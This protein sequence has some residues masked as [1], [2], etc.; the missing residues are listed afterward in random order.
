MPDPAVPTVTPVPAETASSAV[1]ETAEPVPE[2]IAEPQ[3]A[4]AVEEGAVEP[5]TAVEAPSTTAEPAAVPQQ[6]AA[7]EPSPVTAAE[8]ELAVEAQAAPAQ[9]PA[10]A[11]PVMVTEPEAGPA[12]PETTAAI[13]AEAAT[14]E[15]STVETSA[16]EAT[17]AES[18]T[19]ESDTLAAGTAETA[20]VE[21][22]PVEAGTTEVAAVASS[23]EPASAAATAPPAGET[24]GTE[25][26]AATDRAI[27]EPASPSTV[28]L[29]P[30][31]LTE[32][33]R[34][35]LELKSAKESG[36]TVHGR[37]IGWNQGGFHVVIGLVTAF[38]PRSEME[39]KNP[40]S[41]S[42][43][44]DKEFE[45]KVIKHQ[46]KGRRIVLSR[47][48]VLETE[49]EGR[50]ALL[51]AQAAEGGPLCGRISSITDFGAFV[52]LGGVEG[53]VHLT[54]LSHR[55]VPHPRELVQLGQEVRV[56]VLKIEQGGDRISLTMKPFEE[57]PWE[58]F[59]AAHP[60]GSA[61]EGKIARKTD[62][63][64]FVELE[65]GFDGMIHLS[66]LPPGKGLDHGAY[67][68]GAPVTGWILK[69]EPERERI[70]LTL[71]EIPTEDPWRGVSERYSEGT[72][73]EGEVE[74]LTQFGAFVVLEP[75]LTGLLPNSA[76]KALRGPGSTN[77]GL[78][79]GQRVTVQVDSVDTGRK[80]ISL[81]LEG[82]QLTG[83][84]SD[85]KEYQRRQKQERRGMT[86][87]EA[88]FAKLQRK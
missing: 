60:R 81:A 9:E 41:P 80:R 47:K 25:P 48:Q 12:V 52:D 36:A 62:F 40:R 2:T 18:E 16:I 14:V 11:T 78:Q 10:A 54:E 71:R 68:V 6:D 87:M 43:Y 7:A 88:A 15:G 73:V 56:K 46:K 50:L 77:R 24:P 35:V 57:N 84:R 33:D 51:Q 20:P 31:Q 76:L 3:A 8:P 70:S 21:A 34:Q 37:V 85:L 32:H 61:F 44:L 82:Q 79:P 17:S 67:E 53:L 75:G 4:S 49:R 22:T 26:P 27:E 83:N 55:R 19:V 30:E 45:F 58:R 64:L 86:A 63:G 66:Q 42:F 23:T 72:V 59:G 28:H 39:I 38:C 65:P 29:T 74:E 1:T 5:P 69:V 13:T